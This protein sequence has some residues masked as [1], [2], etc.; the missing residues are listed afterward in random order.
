MSDYL[1]DGAVTNALNA[2]SLT[3][4]EAK[5]LDPYL[6]LVTKLASFAGQV[7][8]D[9]IKAIRVTFQCEAA[10]LPH[11]PLVQTAVQAVLG[12]KLDSINMVNALEIA[13]EREIT[14]AST[15]AETRS[16]Y[17]TLISIEVETKSQCR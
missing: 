15:K 6:N 4:E 11:P 10:A 8:E 7:T 16:D 17:Q 3:A 5:L 14:V 12:S 9:E 13:K 2:P 1:L